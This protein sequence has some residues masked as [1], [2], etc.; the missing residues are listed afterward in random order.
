MKKFGKAILITL[1]VIIAMLLLV[2]V[3]TSIIGLAAV[4]VVAP[5]FVGGL[6]IFLLI[7]AI[8]GIIVG[9]HVGKK[10]DDK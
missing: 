6:I 10:K 8:P 7:L 4:A 9:I 2:P 5:G 3:I 1:G